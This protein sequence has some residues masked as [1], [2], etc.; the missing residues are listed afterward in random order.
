MALQLGLYGFRNWV[1]Y[2]FKQCKNELGWS[3]FRLTDYQQIEK[4]WEIVMSAY[5]VSWSHEVQ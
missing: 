1:E 5:S 4:W 3:D 2:A